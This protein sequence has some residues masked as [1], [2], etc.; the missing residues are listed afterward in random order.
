[1]LSKVSKPTIYDG[2]HADI[3]RVF[4]KL[5]VSG[6]PDGKIKPEWTIW[7]LAG[8]ILSKL[9]IFIKGMIVQLCFF[10]I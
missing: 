7:G 4:G 5:Q 8:L 3:V 6:S 1:M 2:T 9:K 10:G